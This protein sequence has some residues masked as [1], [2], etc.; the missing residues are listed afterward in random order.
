MAV[1][2]LGAER[3]GVWA[4]ITTTAVWINLLDLGIAGTL[5]NHISR[6]GALGDKRAAAQSFTNALTITAGAVLLIGTLF[7]G[8]WRRI[9][10]NLVFNVNSVVA[11][12]EVRETVAS[13]AALMLLSLIA[14][15][16]SRLLA[17]YQ[18][19]HVSNLVSAIGALASVT[20]L[21]TGVWLRVSMP[22]LLVMSL[23]GGTLISVINLILVT[24]YYKPWLLPSLSLLDMGIAKDLLSSGWSFFLIQLAGVVVFSSDNL[25]VS[26]YCGAAEVTRY[27]VTWRFVGLAATAQSLLF[28]ALWP[29]YAEAN[30]RGDFAWI[31][32][33]FSTVM[34]ASFALN[35]AAVLFM[36]VFGRT[37]IRWW[38]GAAAIPTIALLLMMAVWA[39][40][41]GI[42]SVESC[43]LAA[44]NRTRRQA[45]LSVLCAAVNLTL[46]IVLVRRVGAVGVITGTVLSYLLVLVVP[47][48][49][50]VRNA[51]RDGC[52][53]ESATKRNRS[54]NAE[55]APGT[56][57]DLSLLMPSI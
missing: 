5:T 57:A 7:A 12:W 55:A 43:L 19:I 49:L 54:P 17:G 35:L 30:A 34:K 36:T 3:Y 45:W 48:S 33:T 6:A 2:Y 47:Q 24:S 41:H 15:L 25:V 56:G 4:T 9:D 31:R 39:I 27:S 26:H 14:S 40:I 11:R 22:V 20:G 8:L 29:A 46:S 52:S 53:P 37:L 42:M 16:G 44:L 38:A 21:A 18:E 1:R 23:G 28:P 50:V 13:A 32:R 10:W 51:L